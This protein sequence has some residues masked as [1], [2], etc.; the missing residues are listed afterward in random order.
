MR[1]TLLHM[2]LLGKRRKRRKYGRKKRKGLP[3]RRRVSMAL[4]VVNT[5]APGLVRELSGCYRAGVVGNLILRILGVY[6]L[7]QRM[8]GVLRGRIF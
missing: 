8:T 7:Q 2:P 6:G 1:E 3:T 4:E 5:L